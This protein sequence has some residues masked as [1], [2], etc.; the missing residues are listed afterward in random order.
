MKGQVRIAVIVF[1]CFLSL[2][3]YSQIP[4]QVIRGRVIDLESRTGLEGA[5]VIVQKSD[6]LL[7]AVTNTDGTFR[8]VNVP[9][10]RHSLQASFMGYKTAIIPEILISSGKERRRNLHF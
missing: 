1:S 9:V 4:T 7:G 5:H 10:G 8:I 6:P 3:S 2:I